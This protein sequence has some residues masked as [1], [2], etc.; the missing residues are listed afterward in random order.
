MHVDKDLGEPAVLVFAG[1]QIDL[2]AADRGLLRVA[3]APVRQTL[4]LGPR[5][6]D[7]LDDPFD[8]PLGDERARAAPGSSS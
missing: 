7:A 1:A 8:D 6:I 4:A 5:T 2:V 3:L